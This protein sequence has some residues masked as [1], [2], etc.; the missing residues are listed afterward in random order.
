MANSGVKLRRSRHLVSY[1]TDRGVVITNYATRESVVA[2]SLVTHVLTLCGDWTPAAA[3]R[4]Q[5]T[6]VRRDAIDSLLRSMVKHSLL[7]RAGDG[8]DPREQAL[9]SWSH[10]NP[11]AGFFHF[12]TK[13]LPGPRN[14]ERAERALREERQ[15]RGS[16]PPV[17]RYA[18]ARTIALDPFR[19]DGE[20]ADV[21]LNRRTWRWFSKEP[22]A[23]ADIGTLLGLTC[24][25]QR[26]ALSETSGPVHLKTSPS[27]GARQPL[28]AY[29]L[30]VNVEGL[31]AGLYHYVSDQHCLEVVRQGATPRKIA[32]YVPGQWWYE[33]AAALFILTAVFGRT[34]WRYR[35]PRAYR[36]V[37]LEA[38]HVCQT[39]CLVATW[40]GLAPFCTG[41]FSD[42]VVERALKVDGVTESFVYGAGVGRR[43]AGVDWAPWPPGAG[44]ND[45]RISE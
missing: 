15:T 4:R 13:N 20:F 17:K 32:K 2:D 19:R 35:F 29:L 40:L 6:G 18:G 3:L 5:L 42:A 37:L 39:F 31:S 41:R 38:G 43:P 45:P 25:V 16:P 10:W 22:V 21:L 7:V 11:A 33:S 28:E 34:Q 24:G 1:W 27:S 36:S 30:A 12:T 26:T 23:L 14:R 9:E 8:G 44:L